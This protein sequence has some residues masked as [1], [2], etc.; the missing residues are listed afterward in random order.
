[1]P[2]AEKQPGHSLSSPWLLILS[3][4]FWM[5]ILLNRSQWECEICPVKEKD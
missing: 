4:D 3:G 1:V 5:L 2:P